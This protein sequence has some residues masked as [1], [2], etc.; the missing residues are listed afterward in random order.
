[1]TKV[2]IV[3]PVYNAEQYLQECIDS[4]LHQTYPF[5]ELI[6][7]DDGSTDQ[8][9]QILKEYARVDKRVIVVRQ[10]NQHAG[11][12]RN[13]GMQFATGKYLLFLDADDFFCENM[14]E[15]LVERAEKD[16]T[17]ILVFDAYH[18]DNQSKTIF[19]EK[20]PLVRKEMIEKEVVSALEISDTIF[21]F[22]NTAP[23]NKLYLKDFIMNN[24]F[25]FLNIPKAEDLY[26]VCQAFTFAKRIAY[27]NEKLLYYRVN[28]SSSLE[29]AVQTKPDAYAGIALCRLKDSLI[30]CGNFEKFSNSFYR[31]ADADIVYNMSK[32]ESDKVF[33]EHCRKLI[34]EIF[35]QIFT[36]RKNPSVDLLNTVNRKDNIT[37]YGAGML[38][39]VI[40]NLLIV[41]CGY[42][43]DKI[44]IVVSKCIAMQ[45]NMRTIAV[46]EISKMEEYKKNNLLLIATME[47]RT[48]KEMNDMA[49]QCH[50]KNRI[51]FGCGEIV[52][53]L[54]YIGQTEY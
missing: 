47:E 42:N 50:V 3:I 44:S 38:C 30:R 54:N 33:L 10:E 43:E 31:R 18:F 22:A 13:N 36:D 16:N 15:L 41:V 4:L 29:G 53:W 25:L 28:N 8:S 14:L 32:I 52:D 19:K 1:M 48:Q 40:L 24:E 51:T 17:E 26:F 34:N 45:E 5:F 2:S 39:K 46:K 23:W 12:A 37:I 9:C 11:V 7:V 20:T 35:P 21:E 49:M 27:L 6:C